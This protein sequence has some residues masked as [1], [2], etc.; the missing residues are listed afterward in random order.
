MV[1]FYDKKVAKQI[2]IYIGCFDL[3][4]KKTIPPKLSKVSRLVEYTYDDVSDRPS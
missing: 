4:K 1:T 3:T 2:K